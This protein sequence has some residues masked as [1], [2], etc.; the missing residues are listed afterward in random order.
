MA[1][2]LPPDH[3]CPWRE[4][5]EELRERLTTVEGQVEEL[6]RRVFG[7]SSERLPP[8]SKE[9]R[10]QGGDEATRRAAMQA[11]QDKRRERAAA[12]AALPSPQTMRTTCSRPSHRFQWHLTPLDMQW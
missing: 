1:R 2:Y 8:V 7:R 5:A 10:Q 4:E 11:T 3:F 6:R 12:R 9:L